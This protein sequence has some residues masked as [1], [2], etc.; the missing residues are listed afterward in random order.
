[1][2]RGFEL[3]GVA[4]VGEFSELEYF[5]EWIAAGHAGEMKY[6]ETRDDAGELKRGALRRVAPWARSVVVCASN[7]NTAQ[8]YSIQ[9]HTPDRGWIP[10]MRGAARTITKPSYYA[11][12]T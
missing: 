11:C 8:P 4:A 2:D 6:L 1:M 7:Y 12:A 10:A 3:A 5:P 9:V